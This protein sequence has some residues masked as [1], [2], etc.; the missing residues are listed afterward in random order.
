MTPP[1]AWWSLW[2]ESESLLILHVDLHPSPD[3]EEQAL[4]LLD[5][6]EQERWKQFANNDARRR[7]TLCRAALRANL[8]NRLGCSNQEL[9]FGYLEHGKPFAKVN[10]APSGEGFNLS[11]SGQHGLIGFSSRDRL[12]VD[13][14]VRAPGRDFDGIASSVYGPREQRALSVAARDEKADVFYR[15]WSLKEAL[16]K[17]LGTGFSLNPSRFEVPEPMIEGERSGMF[18]FPHLPSEPFWLEDLGEPRF[19]AASAYRLNVGDAGP[20]GGL[21]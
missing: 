4:A 13:L 18:R 16:I 20:S 10:G 15:L 12:G 2:R 1:N 21:R 14:E 19:A 7:Y 9:S 6:Q 17:A 5:E 11:H 3:R 8:C